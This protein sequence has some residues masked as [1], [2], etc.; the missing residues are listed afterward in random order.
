[1]ISIIYKCVLTTTLP[2]KFIGVAL[3]LLHTCSQWKIIIVMCC[4]K[5]FLL[6]VL[7]KPIIAGHLN[8]IYCFCALNSTSPPTHFTRAPPSHAKNS[9]LNSRLMILHA[10][11]LA[12]ELFDEV[13]SPRC[14]TFA[15]S[16]A[17]A[18]LPA[19]SCHVHGITQ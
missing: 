3:Q 10:S 8:N 18:K 7:C 5:F 19:W 15:M 13:Q 11:E 17:T 6:C 12:T 1:M 2:F 16:I 9:Y 4:V 14:S